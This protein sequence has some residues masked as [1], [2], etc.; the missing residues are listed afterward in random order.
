M[1]KTSFSAYWESLLGKFRKQRSDERVPD[2]LP[3][4]D[5]VV[6]THDDSSYQ[7]RVSAEIA[8]FENDIVV[9]NLP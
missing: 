2:A 3:R 1:A 7:A 6:T 8:T 5:T 4:Q 9:H